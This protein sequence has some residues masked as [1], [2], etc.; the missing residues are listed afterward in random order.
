MTFDA[1]LDWLYSA[2]MSGIKL[3]LENV[4]RLL[5]ALGNPQ[6]GATFLHVAG[7]NGKGSVCAILDAILRADGRRTGLYTSP[8]LIDFCER[9][10]VDGGMVPRAEVAAGLTAIRDAAHGWEHPPT[11]FEVATVLA[12]WHFARVGCDVVVLETGMGGRL[13][14]TNVVRPAVSVITPI[15]FDHMQWL[16][17]TL[18]AIAAEKAG[19]IK[20]GVPVVIGRLP[21]EAEA[22]VREI[23]A[24]LEARVFSVVEE[25]GADAAA[26]P[27]TNLE[28]E[29]QR[30]NA[31]TAALA[32]RVLPS[33]WNLTTETIERALAAVDWPGRWQR[34]R[35]GERT[36]VVDTSHN[37]EGATVLDANLARL[38]Q[39]TG[40]APVIIG[41]ALGVSRARPLIE[42]FCRHAQ[43][44]HFVMPAQSR[45]C[46]FEE[47]EELVPPG[48]GGRVVRDEVG[49]L[50]PSP[51]VCTAGKPGDVVVVAGSVY[52]AGE[53]LARLQPERGPN[54]G[55]LQ[56]F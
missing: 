8:H 49:R 39:A 28:G 14:A 52:L 34:F 46:R 20:P 56:D 19:I 54:E 53:V 50:F 26:Y 1:A 16:G 44:I 5:G 25:F 11:F 47:L 42:V 43:A 24:P 31:A 36:V 38:G 35:V 23:A 30:W 21:P 12:L 22:T 33:R 29:Y 13:D 51:D 17:D 2:S 10:R 3:G 6:E 55:A 7:T 37:S 27:E 4:R 41:G 48:Y 15:A 40:R 45:A 32:A 9:I 18:A